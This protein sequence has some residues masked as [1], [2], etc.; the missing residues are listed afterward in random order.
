VETTPKP[1][2]TITPDS[3]RIGEWTFDAGTHRLENEQQQI[4]LEPRVAQLLLCL[5]ENSNTAVSRN[6]LME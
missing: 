3:L 1:A 5:A 6:T 4:K 2:K